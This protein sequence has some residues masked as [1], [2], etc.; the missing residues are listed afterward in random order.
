MDKQPSQVLY[1]KW[2]PKSFSSVYGQHHITHTLKQAVAQKR[3]AHSY[4]FCGPRGTGKTST[5]RIF[6]KSIN[7]TDALDGEPCNACRPC[8]AINE[9]WDLDIIEIDAASNNGVDNVRDIREK[10]HFTPGQ[11]RYKVYIIDE[12]HMFSQ[13]AFNAI[14]KTL[15]EPPGHV[16]FILATTEVHRLPATI[17]SRCQRFDFRSISNQDIETCLREICQTE[18]IEVESDVLRLIG[19]NSSGSLRDAQNLLEQMIIAYGSNLSKAKVQ[20]LL[21]I[22]NDHTS[23]ELVQR[24]VSGEVK[25]GLTLLNSIIEEG[26]DPRLFHRQVVNH[27]RGILLFKAGFENPL[28]LDP[29]ISGRFKEIAEST[30]LDNVLFAAQL[31][32]RATPQLDTNPLLPLELALVECSLHI[33][34]DTNPKPQ[35][36]K[37]ETDPMPSDGLSNPRLTRLSDNDTDPTIAGVQANANPSSLNQSKDK[38]AIA[39]ADSHYESIPSS[40]SSDEDAT[41]TIQLGTF[42]E[43]STEKEYDHLPEDQWTSFRNALRTYKVNKFAIGSLLLDCIARYIEGNELILIFKNRTNME[44]LQG[45]MHANGASDHIHDTLRQVTGKDYTLRLSL[46]EQKS[47]NP[48]KPAGHLVRAARA[49][50]AEIVEE[51]SND[52]E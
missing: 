24:I 38:P 26:I 19:R 12:V 2:R 23:L 31:F 9:G 30:T 47:S 48:I 27:L 51:E 25:S 10:V 13:S 39:S 42:E 16:I 8:E 4:L 41:T 33:R 43:S 11:G 29:E 6:A 15:E 36:P 18:E 40:E 52:N 46:S 20:Q 5:A 14:L 44:R 49:F 21:G 22:T 37:Q 34:E 45:E 1:R 50:G 17:I 7:C 3:T 35:T 28:E 32:S